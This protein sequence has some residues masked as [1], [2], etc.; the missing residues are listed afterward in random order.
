M[1]HWVPALLSVLVRRETDRIKDLTRVNLR[2]N[3]LAW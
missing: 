3:V 1:T 2:V